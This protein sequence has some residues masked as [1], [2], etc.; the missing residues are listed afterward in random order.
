MLEKIDCNRSVE[1]SGDARHG[2]T[3]NASE[4]VGVAKGGGS[5]RGLKHSDRSKKSQWMTDSDGN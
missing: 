4:D 3:R 5:E 1:C 2:L